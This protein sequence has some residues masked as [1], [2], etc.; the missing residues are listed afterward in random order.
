MG[1]GADL[2]L[3]YVVL[4]DPAQ[5]YR[6]DFN[7]KYHTARTVGK[8]NQL[9][10]AD[11]A[12]SGQLL[13]RPL[14]TSSPELGVPVNFAEI[15][16]FRHLRVSYKD[17]MSAELST[18]AIFFRLVEWGCL[19][20]DFRRTQGLRYPPDFSPPKTIFC[21]ELLGEPKRKIPLSAST[22]PRDETP[23]QI[24]CHQPSDG[25]RNF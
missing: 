17:A 22:G 6:M 18:G 19:R 2:A 11:D 9:L 7:G 25:L 12:A 5:Y 20:G 1:G 4:V 24:R 16:V 15:T 3:D 10:T 21:P 8:L 23:P 13:G 14:G